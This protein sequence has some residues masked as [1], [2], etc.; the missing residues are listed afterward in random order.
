M[1]SLMDETFTTE[2][3]Y[4][5]AWLLSN[6]HPLVG[7]G[8]DGRYVTFIFKGGETVSALQQ[9]FWNNESIPVRD[10]LNALETVYSIIRQKERE[11][12]N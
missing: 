8:F 7:N 12:R 11:G 9:S 2:D 4:L 10:Y 6:N 5:A 3:R 1:P